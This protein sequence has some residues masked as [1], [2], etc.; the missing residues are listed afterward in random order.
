MLVARRFR[1]FR[2]RRYQTF[3]KGVFQTAFLKYWWVAAFILISYLI[4]SYSL[5][6]KNTLQSSL[7]ETVLKL[8]MKKNLALQQKE[9]LLLKLSSFSDSEW[10][11]LVLM[12][13]LGVVPEG[14]I[15]IHFQGKPPSK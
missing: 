9:E 3:R 1:L 5:Q 8:E 10:I 13:K 7:Q 11:E 2:T 12:Q 14:K 6:Y 15:K 4:Y